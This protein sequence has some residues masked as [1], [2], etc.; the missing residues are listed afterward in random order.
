MVRMK[1]L[2]VI[3]CAI[4]AAAMPYRSADAKDVSPPDRHQV[5]IAG[6]T[7]DAMEPFITPDGSLLLFNNSNDPK[8]NTDLQWARRTGPYSFQYGGR[9][10]GANSAALDGV[11]SLDRSGFLYF[12]STR[13]Y[14]TTFSTVY[15]ARFAEGRATDVELVKGVSLNVPGQVNF[16]LGISGDGN[17]LYGVDGDFTGGPFPKSADIFIARRVGDHFERLSGSETLLAQV[18]TAD[19]EY[20]PAISDDGLTL[21]FTRGTGS[22]FWRKTSV[23]RASRASLQEPFGRPERLVKNKRFPEAPALA[24]GGRTFCYHEKV[25]DVYRIFCAATAH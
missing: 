11:P 18:N 22:L 9:I 16:D 24:D 6:Y 4:A 7:G 23:W 13:S 14:A 1:C 17:T 21:Y 12:V 2:P 10:E 20:A 25:D 15:R 19:L 5:E 3:A 8:V